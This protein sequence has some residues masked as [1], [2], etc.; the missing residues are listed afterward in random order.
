[1]TWFRN[2]FH[3]VAAGCRP[4]GYQQRSGE[5][6]RLSALEVKVRTLKASIGAKTKLIQAVLFILMMSSSLVGAQE[7]VL[8]DTFEDELVASQNSFG[9]AIGFETWGDAPANVTLERTVLTSDSALAREG[10]DESAT[11][12]QIN[13]AIAVGL[14]PEG[15]E[16]YREVAARFNNP[17]ALGIRS[18]A[19]LL[20]FLEPCYNVNLESFKSD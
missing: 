1:M 17:E 4:K 6:Q 10:L 15:L 16:M 20:N 8:N 5:Y 11:V 2:L 12:L 19:H 7:L 9:N 14:V 13:R 18:Y 3:Q